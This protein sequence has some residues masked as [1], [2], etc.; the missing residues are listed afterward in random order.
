MMTE[1]KPYIHTLGGTGTQNGQ[2]G[3]RECANG[4]PRKWWLNRKFKGN[5]VISTKSE[6]RIGSIGHA[7]MD[8]YYRTSDAMLD[9]ARIKFT[10]TAIS[11]EDAD[12]REAQRVFTAYQAMYPPEEIGEVLETEFYIGDNK[13]VDEAVGYPDYTCRLDLMT[14]VTEEDI[15]RFRVTRKDLQIRRPGKYLWDYKFVGYAGQKQL[16]KYAHDLQPMFY[17]LAH[18]AAF[19][20]DKA[21]GFIMMLI[22]KQKQPQVHHILIDPPGRTEQQMVRDVSARALWIQE[23]YEPPYPTNPD[24]CFDWGGMC[25]YLWHGECWRV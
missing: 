22:T 7:F 9:T 18:D 19:P 17:Q 14:N 8:I 24:R 23:N 6:L 12:R 15:E 5:G 20:D 3:I 4:C 11:D 25:N 13:A 10:N 1:P 21:A 2:T 16:E